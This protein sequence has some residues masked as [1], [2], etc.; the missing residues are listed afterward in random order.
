MLRGELDHFI[1]GRIKEHRKKTG[2]TLLKVSKELGISLQQL[3]KYE[4]GKT[5]IAAALLFDLTQ[6]FKVPFTYFY[7]G[8]DS[9][10][11]WKKVYQDDIKS[12]RT[13]PL[14]VLMVESDSIDR[15][16]ITN[17]IL[18]FDRTVN[19]F[20]LEQ[21]AQVYSF[22]KSDTQFY[23]FPKPDVIFLALDSENL[24]GLYLLKEIKRDQ[25]TQ[26]IPVIMFARSSSK[27]DLL[28]C[29]RHHASGYIQ[30]CCGERKILSSQISRAVS[31][32]SSVNLPH[33]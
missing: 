31:Y 17:A 30:K 10:M 11:A 21:E 27:E 14:N 6:I 20:V 25:K 24:D 32:W 33:M 8:Y 13:A 5:R 23:P 15:F 26:D 16:N 3:Q 9:L 19:I 28:K 7:E 18:E 22:L 29:Y 1:G 2:L 4:Q 12:T